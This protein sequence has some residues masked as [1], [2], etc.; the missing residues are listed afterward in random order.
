MKASVVSFLILLLTTAALSA[1]I[2]ADFRRDSAAFRIPEQ[3]SRGIRTEQITCDGKPYLLFSGNPLLSP[4]G[5][6]IFR[7]SRKILHAKEFAAEVEL[8]LPENHSV[9]VFAL[10]FLDARGKR[11]VFNRDLRGMGSGSRTVLFRFSPEAE[12]ADA[13]SRKNGP[14]QFPIRFRGFGVLFQGKEAGPRNGIGVGKIDLVRG[15]DD[16]ADA[17]LSVRSKILFPDPFYHTAPVLRN[18]RLEQ[19]SGELRMMLPKGTSRFETS[20]R[21]NT[22]PAISRIQLDLELLSGSVSV[23]PVLLDASFRRYPCE[24]AVLHPGRNLCVFPGKTDRNARPPFHYGIEFLSGDSGGTLKLYDIRLSVPMRMV[25]A[26]EVEGTPQ[27]AGILLPGTGERCASIRIRNHLETE[28]PLR[29]ELVLRDSFQVLHREEHQIAAAPGTTLSFRMPEMR[30]YGIYYID[31]RL[32]IP[33]RQGIRKGRCSFAVLTPSGPSP[34]GGHFLFGICYHAQRFPPEELELAGKVLSSIGIRAVRCGLEWGK[35]QRNAQSPFRFDS[36]EVRKRIFGRYGIRFMTTVGNSPA[37]ADRK[38][39]IPFLPKHSPRAAGKKWPGKAPP[40]PDAFR[41]WVRAALEYGREDFLLVE[42]WNEPEHFGSANFSPEECAGLQKIVFEEAKRVAPEVLVSTPGFTRAVPNPAFTDPRYAEKVLAAA[43][44]Y[45][46]VIAHHGHDSFDIYRRDIQYLLE[47]RRKIGIERIPW[48]AGET[49]IP[50]VNLTEYEQGTVLFRKLIYAFANG[51]VGYFWYD[52]KNDGTD[53]LNAEHNFGLFTYDFQPKAAFVVYNTLT[54]VLKQAEFEKDCSMDE[55]SL[56]RFR[57]GGEAVYAFWNDSS[58][59]PARLFWL[60]GVK[61]AEMV[62]VFGNVS[63]LQTNRGIVSVEIGSRPGFLRVKNSAG[64]GE[65]LP[66]WRLI[67]AKPGEKN[68]TSVT[69]EFRNPFPEELEFRSGGRLFRV[70]ENG[71]VRQSFHGMVPGKSGEIVLPLEIPELALR[72]R[73]PLRPLPELT[74]SS[75]GFRSSPD[76]CLDRAEQMH[77]LTLN[78][79]GMHDLWRGK[80]DFSVKAFFRRTADSLFLKCI[81]TDD[82]H[83]QPYS[84]TDVWRGDNLQLLLSV[85]GQKNLWEIGFTHRE[86]KAPEVF[87][88]SKGSVEA[89][90]EQIRLKTVRREAEKQTV[91]EAEIPWRALGLKEAPAFLRFHFLANENDGS[92]RKLQASLSGESRDPSRFRILLLE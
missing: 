55:F 44:G 84:G 86:G 74:V 92:G 13:S 18:G 48:I 22:Y 38:D 5:E 34:D 56:Y 35:V 1:G 26:F 36:F 17:W 24:P 9:L 88:W 70:P 16:F 4:Y 60:E 46:D 32:S 39:W 25:D 8:F 62:D 20:R 19:R 2:L 59:T 41:R 50:S 73:I 76:L 51:A 80:D 33:G 27:E 7:E 42:P 53:P 77:R 91:Y 69:L 3:R 89:F 10:H 49:G 14:M 28:T 82:V 85:P 75:A 43:K 87:F 64:S 52:L 40:D 65:I 12:N 31:Y 11:Y 23:R 90:P 30:R 66:V 71:A 47:L 61:E 78:V 54:S 37:W 67:H 45:Y 72:S 81:V 83:F 58:V 21:N 68:G 6:L 15:E 63:R 79:P 29:L 57:A